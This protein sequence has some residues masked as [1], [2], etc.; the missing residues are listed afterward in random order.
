MIVVFC[1]KKVVP[2]FLQQKTVFLSLGASGGH[3]KKWTNFLYFP[4]VINGLNVSRA[5]FCTQ[6]FLAIVRTIWYNPLYG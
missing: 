1:S 6:Y 4:F 3:F 5:T 2:T